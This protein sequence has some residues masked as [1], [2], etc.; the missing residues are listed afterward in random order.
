MS[1]CLLNSP[2]TRSFPNRES[3]NHPARV[4]RSPYACQS[5]Q[6]HHR[7]HV[8]R[9]VSWQF[10][11]LVS[12]KCP[13]CFTVCWTDTRTHTRTP[14]PP[15]FLDDPPPSARFRKL[16][17]IHRAATRPLPPPL[18]RAPATLPSASLRG[19]TRCP[20]PIVSNYVTPRWRSADGTASVYE[21]P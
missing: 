2:K 13:T 11:A 5:H 7:L 19:G 20:R 15:S 17:E 21:S 18:L 12:L 16:T 4:T 6:Y 10:S 9:L 1:H 14:W 3:H 8:C